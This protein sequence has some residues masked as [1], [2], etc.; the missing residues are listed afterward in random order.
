LLHL[1]EGCCSRRE[2]SDWAAQWYLADQLYGVNV[3]VDD[4]GVWDTLE[5]LLAADLKTSERSYLY[6]ETD[7]RAW[8]DELHVAPKWRT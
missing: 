6:D 3:E 8:I 1:A 4:F 5:L 2:A 7:F